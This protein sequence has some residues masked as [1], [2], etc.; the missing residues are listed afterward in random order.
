MKHNPYFLVWA[1]VPVYAFLAVV[2]PDACGVVGFL[3]TPVLLIGA[4]VAMF[5]KRPAKPRVLLALLS[6]AMGITGAMLAMSA[7]KANDNYEKGV[8]AFEKG[9]FEEAERLLHAAGGVDGAA[10]K[11]AQTREAIDAH[12]LQSLETG[13][14]DLD[15]RLAVAPCDVEEQGKA[16]MQTYDR[17]LRRKG[18]DS[19]FESRAD[20]LLSRAQATIEAQ[21]PKELEA[22]RALMSGGKLDEA[23][24]ALKGLNQCVRRA[25]AVR[26]VQGELESALRERT[27]QR[28]FDAATASNKLGNIHEA[29]DKLGQISGTFSKRP[30][31]DA[32]LAEVRQAVK[33][34]EDKKAAERRQAE[35]E[36]ARRAELERQEREAAAAKAARRAELE[37]QE[38]EAA[39][40]EAKKKEQRKERV[41]KGFSGWDGSHIALTRLIKESMNDPDSFD[42]VE[43]VWWDQGDYLIVR[44]KFRGKN[45]FGG[46]VL[47]WVKPKLDLD[48]NVLEVI[49][50][51]P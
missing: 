9:D 14:L 42:H 8:A 32:L 29:A 22:V 6:L 17:K 37:R 40:A 13:L 23:D 4:L 47:N 48:G 2:S 15:S 25:N 44:T 3:A 11:L 28:L 12:L 41:E 43:T 18:K 5:R 10:E 1:A 49:E 30:Q 38:R 34:E 31:A 50:Q 20:A 16:L 26:K 7:K 24:A 51:G 19:E 39:A 35:A 36:A 45:A 33:V 21:V 27:D 46:L